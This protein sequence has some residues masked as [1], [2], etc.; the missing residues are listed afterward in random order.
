M[1]H[2][3]YLRYS[4]TQGHDLFVLLHGQQS[5]KR[6]WLEKDGYTHGGNLTEGL[7][8]LGISFIAFDLRGHGDDKE[9]DYAKEY[10]DDDE[11]ADFIDTS[12]R[13]IGEM[14]KQLKTAE[15]ERKLHLLSYSSGSVVGLKIQEQFGLFDDVFLAVP[16]PQKEYD[17]GYSLHNN[18]G[19]L[20]DG[21]RFIVFYGTNDEEV[22]A[23]ETRWFYD[24]VNSVDKQIFSYPSGH[25]LPTEW[26]ESFLRLI[27]R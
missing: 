11:Y 5:S 1:S 14:L 21:S 12:V 16:I 7:M 2:P 27:Q 6:D 10:L 23:D 26:V 18:I 19:R 8:N 24:Q 15:P 3:P 25:S 20:K 4:S 9:V 22:S 17:D 13:T